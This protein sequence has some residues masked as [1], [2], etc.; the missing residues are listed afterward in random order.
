MYFSFFYLILLDQSYLNTSK[1]EF[2]QFINHPGEVNRARVNPVRHEVIA[3]KTIGSEVLVFMLNNHPINKPK[4][5]KVKAD[6]VL[7]GHIKRYEG[8]IKRYTNLFQCLYYPSII[9]LLSLYYSSII[10]LSSL[11]YP[12]I[13]YSHFNFI[14]EGN[15]YGLAWNPLKS[16]QLLSGSDDG[17]ICLWSI[18]GTQSF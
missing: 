8:H 11:Y 18:D 2:K 14:S 7:E 5:S 4:H 16:H 15:S 17:L 1:I 9:P 6:I 13:M 12:S 10:P 3:T